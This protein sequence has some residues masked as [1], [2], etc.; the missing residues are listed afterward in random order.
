V[1][2]RTHPQIGPAG[3]AAASRDN[4]PRRPPPPPRPP[5]SFAAVAASSR[6]VQPTGPLIS[7]GYMLPRPAKVRIIEVKPAPAVTV[8]ATMAGVRRVLRCAAFTDDE[9]KSLRELPGTPSLAAALRVRIEDAAR[10]NALAASINDILR[11]AVPSEDPK[12]DECME[13]SVREGQHK[14]LIGIASIDP[15]AGSAGTTVHLRPPMRR[16]DNEWQCAI[17]PPRDAECWPIGLFELM[18]KENLLTDCGARIVYGADGAG[19]WL[20]ATVPTGKYI[21]LVSWCHRKRVTVRCTSQPNL[22]AV[23]I[24]AASEQRV[25][26]ERIDRVQETVGSAATGWGMPEYIEHDG[27]S[28][29][30]LTFETAPAWA[31]PQEG[32]RFQD[33]DGDADAY[34][35]A[36]TPQSDAAEVKAAKLPVPGMTPQRTAPRPTTTVTGTTPKTPST[37]TAIPSA[38]IRTPRSPPLAVPE[39]SARKRPRRDLPTDDPPDADGDAVPGTGSVAADS[40]AV[41]GDTDSTFRARSAG[42]RPS[43]KPTTP[44]LPPR[45]AAEAV[46]PRDCTPPLAT[47][48][49][50]P[51]SADVRGA[52][53]DAVAAPCATASASTSSLAPRPPTPPSASPFSSAIAPRPPSPPNLRRGSGL[54]NFPPLPPPSA[55][56]A[57]ELSGTGGKYEF[58]AVAIGHDGPRLY[59]SWAETSKAVLGYKGSKFKGFH[60][61]D[62]AEAFLPARQSRTARHAASTPLAVDTAPSTA[63]S[64]DLRHPSPSG[65]PAGEAVSVNTRDDEDCNA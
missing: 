40:V 1:L 50:A 26:C 47:C 34:L 62:A 45:K 24:P 6:P 13:P 51:T 52:D 53:G 37:S 60:S 54:P 23:H 63:G 3:P 35:I 46:T 61:R 43:Q 14:G 10:G 16:R 65:A 18:K 38:S 8:T 4:E 44:R 19:P 28:I 57:G 2:P 58:Y 20:S 55:A 36:P 39:R 22:W 64:S 25:T 49:A 21:D 11:G 48:V 27:Q 33:E 31:P 12:G 15:T 17:L 42:A 32:L 29:M 59:T 7:M 9:R 30:R 41:D 5:I 56:A